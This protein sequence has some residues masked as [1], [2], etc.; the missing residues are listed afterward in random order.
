MSLNSMKVR[1]AL[2][3]KPNTAPTSPEN[4]D[5]YYD[6]GT[7]TFQFY[8]NGAFITYGASGTV[9]ALGSA[10][11]STKSSNYTITGPDNGR[12]FF[13]DTTSAAFSF[14]LPAASAGFI[15]TIK[16]STGK[17]GTNTCTLA[18]AASESIEGVAASFA[19]TAI[20]GSWTFVSDGT[21]W[22]IVA[23]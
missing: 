5:I 11:T 18:R 6:S 9:T 12:I 4:G 21:N 17:F 20:W 16:D 1:N 19:M 23:H 13:A 7:N 8:Q 2:T 15:F 14:T 3:L 22:F 10:G